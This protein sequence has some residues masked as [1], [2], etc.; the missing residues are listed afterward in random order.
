M[1]KRELLLEILRQLELLQ[2][3]QDQLFLAVGKIEGQVVQM[4]ASMTKV[5]GIEVKPGEPVNR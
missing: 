5:V 4:L 3:R 1:S 2:L